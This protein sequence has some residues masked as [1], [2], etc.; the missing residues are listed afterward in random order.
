MME[1]MFLP[2]PKWDEGILVDRPSLLT[3][4][5]RYTEWSASITSWILWFFALRP[6][7]V[8]VLWGIGLHYFNRYMIAESGFDNSVFFRRVFLAVWTAVASM[9]FFHSYRKARFWDRPYAPPKDIA[10]APLLA[11]YY[12]LDPQALAELQR[13]HRVDAYFLPGHRLELH[14][15]ERRVKAAGF[16]NPQQYRLH[17]GRLRLKHPEIPFPDL[18]A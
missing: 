18:P 10:R 12:D 15:P 2:E 14:G 17:L 13:S 9:F 3:K 8:T 1:R 5:R 6:L 7:L 16:F 11:A 4:T